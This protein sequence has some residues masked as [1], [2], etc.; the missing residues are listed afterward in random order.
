MREVRERP[1]QQR[2]LDRVEVAMEH[3][4]DQRGD[5]FGLTTGYLGCRSL[6]TEGSGVEW[7]DARCAARMELEHG[8][9]ERLG[10]G[11][12]LAF[13]IRDRDPAAE[14]PDRSVDEALD[15]GALAHAD[16]TGD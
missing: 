4:P 2:V 13:R 5:K 16:I 7:I 9:A 12:V 1:A 15:R 14:H 8:E 11:E 10:Q 3:L 6:P